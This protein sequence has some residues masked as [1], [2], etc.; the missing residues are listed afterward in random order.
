MFST[1]YPALGILLTGWRLNSAAILSV[2]ATELASMIVLWQVRSGRLGR[3]AA[4]GIALYAAYALVVG[5][6]A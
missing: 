4:V 6:A 1:V 2:A 5:I 3:V